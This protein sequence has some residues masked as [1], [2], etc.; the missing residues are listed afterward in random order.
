MNRVL[1][2]LARTRKAWVPALV[3]VVLWSLVVGSIIPNQIAIAMMEPAGLVLNTLV[4][5]VITWA[6]PNAQLAD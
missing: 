3:Q 1:H 5:M 4:T 6:V 2:Y